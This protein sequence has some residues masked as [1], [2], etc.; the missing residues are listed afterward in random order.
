MSHLGPIL[1]QHVVE[2]MA[3]IRL[4]DLRGGLH[5]LGG[6]SDLVADELRAARHFEVGHGGGDR[7]RIR[8]LDGR[9]S[10]RQ[11]QAGLFCAVCLNQAVNGLFALI[12]GHHKTI[13]DIGFFALP[14]DYPSVFV[15][16]LVDSGRS[17][18]RLICP[19]PS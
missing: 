7:V 11:L 6:Q 13:L 1:D 15:R 19:S 9:E 3:V 12:F 14:R 18:L 8:N 17:N 10:G 2:Q 4:V 16:R 5:C